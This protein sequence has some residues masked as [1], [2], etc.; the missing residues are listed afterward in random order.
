[1]ANTTTAAEQHVL[2][3]IDRSDRFLVQQV[4]RPAGERRI[5]P[6]AAGSATEASR[7]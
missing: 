4:F 7:C 2:T 5:S 6:P 3:T 1:M